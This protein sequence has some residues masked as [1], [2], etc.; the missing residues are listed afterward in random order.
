[1][2]RS[3]LLFVILTSFIFSCANQETQQTLKSSNPEAELKFS[4]NPFVISQE[5]RQNN[6]INVLVFTKTEGFRHENISEGL[7]GLR[8]LSDQEN[9][10]MTTTE[11]SR[12]FNIPFLSEFDVVI[13]L[14]TT[15][16]ILNEL[17]EAAF[18]SY[19]KSGGGFLGI[20]AAADTEYD[21]P[22]YQELISAQFLGH[23]PTQQ[24]RLKVHQETHHPSI[25][26]L[27]EVWTLTDEWYYFKEPL[28]PH[29]MVLMEIDD[30]S[31]TEK[32][33]TGQNYPIAWAH[34]KFEGRVVYTG[35]G[36]TKELFS[37]PIYLE[38]LKKSIQ[39][40]AGKYEIKQIKTWQNLLDYDL[41]HWDKYLGVPHESV[42]LPFEFPKQ[43]D[44]RQGQA[45]G[46]N[47]DPLNVFSIEKGVD[48]E[49]ILHI[50][51][52]I[53]GSL[54]YPSDEPIFEFKRF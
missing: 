10:N 40:S 36:H 13:F 20:H 51:G 12:F 18:E 49:P 17:E 6:N 5:N 50:T 45:L 46:L 21:W 38:H 8:I 2:K 32:S 7:K 47:N 26:H 9:W 11:D 23:Q 14:N 43:K 34:Q 31:I 48:G 1:M 4:T 37:D 30:S 42:T 44:V 54:T 41:T 52:E 15:G 24:A 16:D 22:F 33:P 3:A 28:K 25:N 39:W 53:Y 29:A 35:I 19:I 27:D